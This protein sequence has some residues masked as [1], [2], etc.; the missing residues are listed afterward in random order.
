MIPSKIRDRVMMI[1]GKPTIPQRV[2]GK[3]KR[4][5]KD[6]PAEECPCLRNEQ[7]IFSSFRI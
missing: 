7:D 1:S 3:K 6:Y 4:N 5:A 2:C